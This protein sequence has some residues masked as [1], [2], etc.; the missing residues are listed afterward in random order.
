MSRKMNK[1][2]FAVLYAKIRALPERDWQALRELRENV[3]GTD[4][5]PIPHRRPGRPR[6]EKPKTE[7]SEA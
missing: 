7:Q 3:E 2:D 5:L 6:V 1:L 4:V